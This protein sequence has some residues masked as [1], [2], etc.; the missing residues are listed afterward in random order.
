MAIALAGPAGAGVLDAQRLRELF[1]APYVVGEKDGTIPVWPV[2]KQDGP[3][4]DLVCYV[5]ESID[6]AAIPGFSGTPM[7]LLVALDPG[8]QYL[9]VRVLSHHEPVFLDGLGEEPLF[10]FV[11]Q[12]RGLS[13]KQTIKIGSG[14]D[15]GSRQAS[16]NAYVDGVAKAT[17]SVRILNQSVL[18][19]ALKVARVKL[20]FS[21]GKDPD[22]VAHVRGEL[23]EA[24]NWSQLQQA[25][26]VRHLTLRNRDVEGA[27]AGTAGAGIDAQA[28]EHPDETFID[29]YAAMVSVP[30]AGRNLLAPSGYQSMLD[31]VGPGDH[32]M[33]L[34]SSGR[35]NFVPEDFVRA[36]VP[37]RLTLKQDGLPIEM[38]DLDLDSELRPVGQPAFDTWKAFRVIAA[39]GLDP[40]Q[41][42]DIALRVVRSKGIVY[43]ERVA[44]D[45]PLH[46]SIPERFVVP[47]PEDQKGW[48]AMWKS[49][50]PSI[51]VLTA[52][53][54][55][56]AALL[57]R[58]DAVLT[59]WRRLRV[60]RPMFLAFTVVF[61]GW[62][63]QAQLSIV[64]VVALLQA[65]VAGRS[66][67]FFLFDPLTVILWAF[68][69]ATLLVWGRGTFCGWLCPFGAL[70][71]L[72]ALAGRWL[73]AP[74]LK[75]RLSTDRRLKRVK[76]AVL[77]VVIVAALWSPRAG[78]WAVEI[79]PFKTAITLLFVRS[80]PFAAY[81]A[82]LVLAGV[83]VNKFFC[84]YLCPLGAW[85]ALLGRARRLDWIARRLECGQP[86]QTCRHRCDYQA[87]EPSGRI[88]YDE[89]FQCM[90]CVAIHRSDRLCAPR[91][92]EAKGGRRM[93]VVAARDPAG[94]GPRPAP[95]AW[96]AS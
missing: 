14:P 39:A 83:V 42:I 56:L 84:R 38:H 28:V 52:A 16:T 41:P 68:V 1:P 47:A 15:R 23:F 33:L 11:A 3:N 48:R 31:R 70:Q 90:D 32:V 93:I 87:I 12:Y 96:S 10:K 49:R 85:L 30:S 76:Y 35:Y 57:A 74:R 36:S 65:L 21:A 26:L 25:G 62:F 60:A 34:M 55:I 8:G 29:L 5:F 94:A 72:A 44:R 18:S 82:A 37:D 43:P 9:D 17:A 78:D 27:F 71:E 67:G 51:A 77:A 24:M 80:W 45:F 92:L 19:A 46:F 79:E 63:A 20:G 50:W 7:N 88:D 91:I 81:A 53:L 6:F 13:L 22:L 59:D 61:I 40:G 64:N 4:T 89:C 69:L 86:C 95:P 66:L 73:R 75:L 54:A 2:F 58:Q